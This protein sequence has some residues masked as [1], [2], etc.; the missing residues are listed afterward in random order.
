MAVS[1]NKERLNQDLRREIIHIVNGMKD[2]RLQQ[3]LLTV[4]RVEA[5]QDLSVARVFV[6]VL[7]TDGGT[8]AQDVVK[9]L[10]KA[11]GYIRSEIAARMHIRRAPQ[12]VFVHD[13]S[14]A[15]ADHI[16]QVLKTLK[17]EV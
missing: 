9:A 11:K 14:A 12:L 2:P 17:D 3:G 10:D 5:A 8:A 16:N 6:S 7:G 15:Y 4:T 13:D 1:K